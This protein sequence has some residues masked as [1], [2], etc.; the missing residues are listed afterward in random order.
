M[1][2]YWNIKAKYSGMVLFFR[3]GDFYEMFGDDAVKAAPVLEVV[4]TRRVG[5]PMCGVPYH[6]VNSYIRKLITKGFKVAICE[7]LEESG[8]T[9]G[10]V[11]RGVTKVLTPGTILE[12]TLLES[13]ENNFLMSVIFDDTAASATFAAAD[14]ST[15]EFFVSETTLKSIEAEVLKY[16]PGELI[17]S[18]GSRQNKHI[19]DFTA[20]L[21]VTVSDIDNSFFDIEKAQN[22]T[23]ELFGGNAVKKFG[24]NKKEIVC[25]CGA[26]LAY[27]KEMQPQSVSIFSEIKYIR[28]SDFMYLDTA[29]I[30]NL[31]LLNSM[32]SGKTENSLLSVMDSTK[33]PMGARTIRQWL[34]KPLLDISKIKNRQNIVRFFIKNPNVRKEIVEKLKTVSDI[35]RI[36]ARVSSGSANPKDLTAL[37]NSLKTINNISEIIK[38]A[39]GL[40]FNIPENAQITNKISSYLSD[41]PPVSVKDGNVIKNGVAAELDELR[42]I[43]TD[44]KAYIS[45]LEAKERATSGINN[46][47]IGYTSVF[48]YYIEISKSNAASAPKHYVRKQT[49][50]AGERYITEELKILEEK[51]LS[52]Q[53]KTLRL[54]NSLF[55]N[56][57]QEISV[58]TADILKT[59]Q[60]ISEIDIFCGFAENATEYNYVCPK[61]SEGR[62]LSIKDGR[63]P[64]VERILKNGEFTANDIAFGENSKIMILTGP[65]MSGKS[66]YLRQTAL[67][68]IMAQIGSFVPSQS[69]EIGLVDKIF[70]R[71]GAGDNLAGGESTFMVEMSETAN[72]MNQYTQRS[73]I[74]LD[75]VG[76]G[77]STYDGM[78]IAWA[79]IEFFADDKRK[80]NTGA[81][82][83]FATHYFEL[84]GLSETLKG[85][86]NYSVDIKEWNGDVIFLHKI[87]KGSA[88]KS[89]G[90]Y[91]AKIAG[92]PHQ[93]IERAYEILSRLEKNSVE[94]SK[95]DESPQIEFFRDSGDPQILTELK[96]IDIDS[97]SPIEAFNIMHN[98]KNKYK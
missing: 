43:S 73:L 19:S 46:L 63:H 52:A 66:T 79:I 25:A 24:L 58:F 44:T 57:V 54:E 11:K 62:E 18:A 61:I 5:I 64:V 95:R 69:A 77:T 34:I 51:I 65:N 33:T 6:S 83:L 7:Q 53:E 68:V 70:T 1:K 37:K 80:A 45:N 92:M 56:L 21:K 14:I 85:V 9:K 74:I 48:G 15:G 49:V 96:N 39:E 81:K 82:I 67:I 22:I 98:W 76:R 42:K 59:S 10:I 13:K 88:D 93:V 35:E 20:K 41:E 23:A 26:L 86:V 89:Y 97:L 71:I 90:I 94:Y 32:T 29:A 17:I 55:N 91:V 84:T 75:E 28:N 50:T 38:S 4:L 3:L 31:E 27:I 78:S 60:I 30:K 87:V 16:N 12:D 8:T 40:G 36:T 47:K 72:I 2:Q